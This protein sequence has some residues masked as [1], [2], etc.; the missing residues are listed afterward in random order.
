[1][2][3]KYAEAVLAVKFREKD[4]FSTMSGGP[5]YYITKGLKLKWLGI[6]FSIFVFLGAISKLDLVWTFA[7]IM[8]GLMAIPN[9]I[10]LLGLSGIV[11]VETKEYFKK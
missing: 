2:A 8:N 4:E 10:A 11:A 1:M 9:L 7:D 3:T 5:M 6:I